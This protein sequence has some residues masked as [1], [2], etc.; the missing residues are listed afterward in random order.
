M[1]LESLIPVD[2]P[3]WILALL[4]SRLPGQ[5]KRTFSLA[6]GN[7]GLMIKPLVRIPFK[8]GEWVEQF[9]AFDHGSQFSRDDF[10]SFQ[11]DELGQRS[12]NKS[13]NKYEDPKAI[14]LT[15][16]SIAEL[17]SLIGEFKRNLAEDL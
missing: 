15:S 17:E 10:L 4:P 16:I 5:V 2:S 11:W 7:Q 6:N 1:Q 8:N 9:F 14:S 3:A 13:K 12:F